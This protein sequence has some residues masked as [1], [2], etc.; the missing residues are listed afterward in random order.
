[1]GRSVR[2][3][4]EKAL[5]SATRPP[6]PRNDMK[7]S[8]LK[9][10]PMTERLTNSYIDNVIK[11]SENIMMQA[12]RIAEL[13][14]KTVGNEND[15]W[16]KLANKQVASNEMSVKTK[17]VKKPKTVQTIIYY[18]LDQ[19]LPK[20]SAAQRKS[21]MTQI[22]RRIKDQFTLMDEDVEY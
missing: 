12:E 7:P 8:K 9:K 21:I 10:L 17:T 13:R 16:S 18:V 11:N 19:E 22:N 6:N 4:S 20:L 5:G 1:M 3:R 14:S 2:R 15:D